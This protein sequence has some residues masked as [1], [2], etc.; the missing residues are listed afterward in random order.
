MARV[1]A[2]KELALT[3]IAG[4][5]LFAGGLW[6]GMLRLPEWR[7]ES[8]PSRS[9][10][11][12]RFQEAAQ[13]ARIVANNPRFR[14]TSRPWIDEDMNLTR[15]DPIYRELGPAAPDWLTAHGYGPYIIAAGDT[16]G[17]GSERGR[18][19]ILSTL[20]GTPISLSLVSPKVS[21]PPR[22]VATILV[23]ARQLGEEVAVTVL[24]QNATLFD[25]RGSQPPEYV[26]VM[27]IPGTTNLSSALRAMGSIAS[28]RQRLERLDVEALLM[29]RLPEFIIGMILFLACVT[30]FIV[31]LA[32]RRIDVTMGAILAALSL[33]F[34]ISLPV[35]ES[36]MWMMWLESIGGVIGRVVVIFVVWSATESWIRTTSPDFRT[37][38][39]AIR[40]GQI[41][42]AGGRAL[43]GGW[44]IG[45]AAAGIGLM[46]ITLSTYIWGI[47]PTDASVHLPVFDKDGSP[48]A[49]GVL[50]AGFVLLA[51]GAS[52]RI[53]GLRRI[54]F[55]A[56]ILA[57][58]FLS[59]SLP[60]LAF[61]F[62]IP[63]GLVIATLFVFAYQ[64]FGLAALL[65]ASIVSLAL[66]AALYGTKHF[67]WLGT[68]GLI[69]MGITAVPLLAGAIGLRRAEE[70]QVRVPGFVR[71]LEEERRLQ[72][73]MDLL[74][75]MQIGLLPRETPRIE[76]YEVAAKSLLATEAGGDLYDFL[77]DERG[78]IWIAAGDVSGHG[79]SC[80]VAQAMTKAGL[81]SLINAEQT[82]ALVL[83]RLDHV[84][85]RSGTSRTFTSLA[86]LRLDPARGEGLLANAGHP[87]PLHLSNG[88]V[89]EFAISALPLGQGPPRTY[90][91]VRVTLEPGSALVFC[92]D[93][94]FEAADENGVAYGF[95]RVRQVLLD[96]RRASAQELLDRMLEDWRRHIGSAKP[97]DDTTIVVLKRA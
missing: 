70:T 42:P 39:D 53:P 65:T 72:H 69:A 47:S 22:E 82:P 30:L 16:R 66:P 24:G 56:A 37:N 9:F 51:I 73:E 48:V 75:R 27:R 61:W 29:E 35:D 46:A 10:F 60:I 12:A 45:A 88:R 86:L 3:G 38:L 67:A 33:A 71:R 34:S 74:A 28:V 20:R 62:A 11:S 7:A 96:G 81:T 4:V 87:Y 2:R 17:S 90:E 93:G 55:L 23:P 40:A 21:P 68:S 18:M 43:L 13:R 31:L 84:L 26:A 63:T 52:L 41:G 25:V 57:G 32:K 5:T 85:R 79:F 19:V 95:E 89:R 54:P 92:S 83:A 15:F 6:M 44:F 1:S 76:G 94:L 58:G 97:A 78:Q 36:R 91:D 49:E 64:R 80:A 8:I 59:T 50:R 77:D 14:A